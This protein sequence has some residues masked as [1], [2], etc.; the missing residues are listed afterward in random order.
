MRA[1]PILALMLLAGSFAGCA[2][3]AP[4]KGETLRHG[5][6]TAGAK[7]APP[8]PGWA[9]VADAKIR[10]GVMIHT[11]KGDCPSNFVFTKTDNTSVFIGTTAYCV[12][13]MHV[14]SVAPI[15]TNDTIGVLIYSSFE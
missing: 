2:S 14:G 3:V 7:L 5:V 6:I 11:P 10:P 4:S 8:S 15:G 12:R 13:E 9:D 1:A